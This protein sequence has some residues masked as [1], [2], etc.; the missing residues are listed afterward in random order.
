MQ[1]RGR[2]RISFWEVN[3]IQFL[4]VTDLRIEWIP[5]TF[6]HVAKCPKYLSFKN[7]IETL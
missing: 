3:T 2:V 5:S 1:A 7:Y 4:P 6:V